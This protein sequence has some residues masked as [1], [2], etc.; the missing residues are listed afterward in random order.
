M[1]RR[2]APLELPHVARAAGPE[3]SRS[4]AAPPRGSL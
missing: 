3:N 2:I 4:W 1:I